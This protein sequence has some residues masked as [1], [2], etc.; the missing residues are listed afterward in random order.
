MNLVDIAPGD[1]IPE[2]DETA[3]DQEEAPGTNRSRS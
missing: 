2:H 1:R 3:R